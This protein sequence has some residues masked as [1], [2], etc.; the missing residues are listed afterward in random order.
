MSRG[1]LEHGNDIL[2]I[3]ASPGRPLDAH[4]IATQC[5]L[6]KSSAYRFLQLLR[7][8]GLVEPMRAHP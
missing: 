5:R 3:V 6:P 8:R 1:S 2:S 4:A 7:R